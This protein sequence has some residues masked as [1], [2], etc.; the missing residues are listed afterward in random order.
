MPRPV[1][2]LTMEEKAARYDALMARKR[3]NNQKYYESNPDIYRG[4]YA[5]N[6]EKLNK[7]GCELKR[8]KNAARKAAKAATAEAP[9]PGTPEVADL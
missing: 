2:E 3:A 5:A 1:A 4:H 6:K 8:E 9:C 7:R